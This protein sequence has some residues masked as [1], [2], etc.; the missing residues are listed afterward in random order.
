M[1]AIPAIVTSVVYDAS[2]RP[3]TQT[4]ANGTVTANTYDPERGF[5]TNILTT[6]NT[7]TIQNLGYNLDAAGIATDVTSPFANEGWMPS[8]T[9]TA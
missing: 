1:A 2:G 8:T 5:L 4:N 7:T 3:T 9:C 6:R